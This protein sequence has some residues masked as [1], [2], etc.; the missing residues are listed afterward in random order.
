LKERQTNGK[1]FHAHELAEKILLK[2]PYYP[3]AI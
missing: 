1:I 2:Y 3:K